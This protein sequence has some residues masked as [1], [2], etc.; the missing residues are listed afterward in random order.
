MLFIK[1]PRIS[2]ELI[3]VH[4]IGIR[5]KYH[6]VCIYFLNALQCFLH[7]VRLEKIIG[8][9]EQEI[10]SLCSTE[11]CISRSTGSGIFLFNKDYPVVFLCPTSAYIYG[12]IIRLVIH[13]YYLYTLFCLCTY[14][15]NTFIKVLHHVVHRNY[16]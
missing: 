3:L 11:S 16:Y 1:H 15:L 9:K 12:S 13:K 10:L 2:D 6:K 7:H 14:A 5:S 4:V 8:I